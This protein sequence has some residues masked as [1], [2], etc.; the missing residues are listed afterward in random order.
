MQKIFPLS[1]E[2]KNVTALL[3]TFFTE[4]LPK[5]GLNLYFHFG[6]QLQKKNIPFTVTLQSTFLS[7]IFQKHNIK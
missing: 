5:L 1:K 6:S 3:N 4:S 2:K 7:K